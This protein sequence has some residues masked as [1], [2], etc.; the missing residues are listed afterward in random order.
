M[1]SNLT[2]NKIDNF[3]CNKLCPLCN[4]VRKFKVIIH[5]TKGKCLSGKKCLACVS[6]KNNERLKSKNYYKTYYQAHAEELKQKDK[7]R[8]QK[9]KEEA[10]LVKFNFDN[11]NILVRSVVE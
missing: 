2:E 8:Y 10:N 11:G 1:E 3:E 6:A 4:K 5:K 9:R 7:I